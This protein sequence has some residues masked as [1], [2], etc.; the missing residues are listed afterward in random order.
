MKVCIA[1]KNDIACNSVEYMVESLGFDR[2]NL[3]VLPSSKNAETW[4]KDIRKTATA[5]GLSLVSLEDVY[6]IEDVIF[7]SLEFDKIIKPAK[8]KSDKL[9]NIHFSLLPKYKGVATSVI[10]ILNG[11]SSSGTTLHL[12]DAGIDTG[13]IIA[14]D[15]FVLDIN[16]CCRDLYF[17]YMSSAF[18]LFK[19]NIESLLNGSYESYP[20]PGI[21]ASYHGRNYID[22]SNIEINLRQSSFQIHNQIRAFIYKE[23]QLPVVGGFQISRSRFTNMKTSAMLF[24]KIANKILLSGID[25][26]LV[27]LECQE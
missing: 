14:Q 13:D 27:E 2:S 17:K 7:I 5:N 24:E 19:D 15:E 18:S 8:F 20:Q 22:F 9:F 3:F 23:Y 25:G 1:G 10:P 26:Y 11:E 4:L 12:I 6:D 16:D 21:G